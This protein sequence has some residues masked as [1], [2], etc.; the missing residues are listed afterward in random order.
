[1]PPLLLYGFVLFWMVSKRFQTHHTPTEWHFQSTVRRLSWRLNRTENNFGFFG[2]PTS[3]PTIYFVLVGSLR[4][5]ICIDK[6]GRH[7]YAISQY[8]HCAQARQR[9]QHRI[10][11]SG[12]QSWQASSN[13]IKRKSQV[14]FRFPQWIW[15]ST[16][17]CSNHSLQM[18]R[19]VSV[20][21]ANGLFIE[22]NGGY[23]GV[24]GE[25][26][27]ANPEN[28]PQFYNFALRLRDTIH[29]CYFQ[30]SNY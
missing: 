8:I 29:N 15:F 28:T 19:Y 25:G 16:R 10:I 2:Y 13:S 20:V 30:F 18:R 26:G 22:G 27:R 11:I 6:C 12:I 9:H 21:D 4:K 14:D 3:V 5:H 17:F 24:G 1:M 7:C 23:R